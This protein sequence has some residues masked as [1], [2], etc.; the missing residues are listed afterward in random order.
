[1]LASIGN[2]Y[3]QMIQRWFGIKF[4]GHMKSK[5]NSLALT[6]PAVFGLS[7]YYLPPQS[8]VEVEILYFEVVFPVRVQVDLTA[9]RGQWIGLVFIHRACFVKTTEL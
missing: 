8:H 7:E 1:M 3:R 4:C 2:M 9:L 5:S 6:Q